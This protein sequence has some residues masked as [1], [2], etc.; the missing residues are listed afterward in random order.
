MFL[1]GMEFFGVV[2]GSLGSKD[3]GVLLFFGV[4]EG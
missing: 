4:Q 2:E 1:W 3:L